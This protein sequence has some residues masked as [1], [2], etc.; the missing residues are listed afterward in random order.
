M[1]FLMYTESKSLE[2]ESLKEI[3]SKEARL[4][5]Y[6]TEIL[7][8]GKKKGRFRTQNPELVGNLIVY[9]FNFYTLRSWNFRKKY[10]PS[11]ITEFMI[12]FILDAILTDTEV[13]Q[14][15]GSKEG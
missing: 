10:S 14:E 5:N 7:E 3:L 4:I 13:T 11:Q 12:N 6:F 9:L 8:N 15:S 2:K 1:G